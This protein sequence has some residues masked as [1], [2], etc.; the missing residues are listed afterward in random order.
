MLFKIGLDLE[1]AWNNLEQV[2]KNTKF[3]TTN[4]VLKRISHDDTL[5]LY[6]F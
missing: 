1:N 3:S 5:L 4:L 6:N 2:R